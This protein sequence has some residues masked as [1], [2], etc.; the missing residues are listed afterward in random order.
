MGDAN[1]LGI[2]GPE[3]VRDISLALE[4]LVVA[5]APGPGNVVAEAG[6]GEDR[7]PGVDPVHGDGGEGPACP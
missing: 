7:Q 2:R 3:P 6:G 1:T 5:A 4:Y